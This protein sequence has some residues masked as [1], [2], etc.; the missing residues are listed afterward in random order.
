MKNRKLVYFLAF[1]EM[2]K[3]LEKLIQNSFRDEDY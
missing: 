1:F 3:S 2:V